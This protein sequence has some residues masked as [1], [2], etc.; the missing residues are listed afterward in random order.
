ME[1]FIRK[2]SKMSGGRFDPLYLYFNI[3]TLLKHNTY[4]IDSIGNYIVE[5]KTGF[6]AGKQD[7]TDSAGVIQIRPTN[8]NEN[9]Q[10]KFDKN[11]YVPKDSVSIGDYIQKGEVLFNNT[12]SQELV[13]KTAYFDLEDNFVCSNHITRIKTKSDK[14]LP[15]YLWILLNIYQKYKIFFNTCVN[16][17]NQSGINIE[18]LKSYTIPIPPKEIQ[19]QIINIMNNAYLLKKQKENEARDI[20]DSIDSY[21]LDELDIVL[22]YKNTDLR[23]RIY[24]TKLSS[25]SGKRFDCEYHQSYY[26]ELEKSLRQGKY[27]LASISS[28]I[29]SVKKGIEVGSNEYV[30]EKAIPFIRVSDINNNGIDFE[31]VDKFITRSLYDNLK[32]DFQPQEGE[33]LYSKDGTIGICL[34]ANCE[35]EYI[36]SGAIVRI[37]IDNAVNRFFIQAL[38]TSRIINAL[39]NRNAIGAIIKHL[40]I[41]NL[42]NLKIP[43]P[44]L[45][46]QDKIADEIVR[47]KQKALHLQKEAKDILKY[48]IIKVE[49]IILGE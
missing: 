3:Q 41:D 11:I 6:A 45:H 14:L 5:I 22:P 20:L 2:W 49:K 32:A 47:R 9:G 31:S 24:T 33:L 28:V 27:E 4:N 18:L 38:L 13:G 1:I 30:R 43:L 34:E 35:K 40:T 8:L 37:A 36:I 17:N 29:S 19:Q 44:P 48:A 12:N 39:A 7:Q 10:L 16:W 21:L 15:K 26:K 25:I 46:V 23:H 42:L